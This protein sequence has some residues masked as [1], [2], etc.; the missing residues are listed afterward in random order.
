MTGSVKYRVGKQTETVGEETNHIMPLHS[1]LIEKLREFHAMKFVRFVASVV[2]S[3]AVLVSGGGVALA[4]PPVIGQINSTFVANGGHVRFG[5]PLA[6][7]V[8]RTLGKDNLY[9]QKFERG[10]VFWSKKAGGASWLVGG[11]PNLVKVDNERDALAPVG[12]SGK[13]YRTARLCKAN[14]A[15][16]HK[17]AALADGGV[18]IDLRSASTA[19]S[20]PDPKLP[21]VK[22][23]RYSMTGTTNLTKFVTDKAQRQQ[24]AKV[25]REIANTDGPVVVHCTKGRD[26]TGWIVILLQ[27]LS[28]GGTEVARGEYLKSAGTKTANFDKG[29]RTLFDRYDGVED[30]LLSSGLTPAEL[31]RLERKLS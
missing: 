21:G 26:R 17:L 2:L 9:Y 8:K 11:V 27:L 24:V 1:L 15:D 28:G 18:I 16:K 13:V 31:K 30:Y 6:P 19:R 5:D 10:T 22:S 3:A 29:V 14:T 12:A 4:V 23:V 20:C 7:E 25:M